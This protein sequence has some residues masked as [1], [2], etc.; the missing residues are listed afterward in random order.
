MTSEDKKTSLDTLFKII[1]NNNDG[2]ISKSDIEKIMIATREIHEGDNYGAFCK[3]TFE[4]N[5]RE[6]AEFLMKKLDEKH[7]GKGVTKE[8]FISTI[9]EMTTLPNGRKY[10]TEAG[11]GFQEFQNRFDLDKQTS[12]GP[13]YTDPGKKPIPVGDLIQK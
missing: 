12:Y 9:A 1:D 6:D 4:K 10:Y 2:L 3:N 11:T 8:K 13:Y 7:T 5:G